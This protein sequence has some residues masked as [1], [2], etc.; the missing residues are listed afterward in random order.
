M[1]DVS[2]R[3]GSDQPK[4][5]LEAIYREGAR[6]CL[7]P[8]T[9]LSI[10]TISLRQAAPLGFLSSATIVFI[11]GAHLNRAN[12]A[13]TGS[14]WLSAIGFFFVDGRGQYEQVSA[15]PS[16]VSRDGARGSLSF[17][18]L[19]FGIRWLW[20]LLKEKG[21]RGRGRNCHQLTS[22]ELC[23][24]VSHHSSWFWAS[25]PRCPVA[26]HYE[27]A[28]QYT[29]QGTL[30]K[31]HCRCHS[32]FVARSRSVLPVPASKKSNSAL[33]GATFSN[34]ATSYFIVI[35]IMATVGL[36]SI[37]ASTHDVIGHPFRYA[38]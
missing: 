21:G 24:S 23:T 34:G 17:E 22:E 35:L 28:A 5:P 4:L 37:I 27:D 3:I 13:A 7:F 14:F 19:M 36:L 38:R 30:A 18:I 8:I 6:K 26:F 12:V 10:L 16:F 1:L 20:L 15:P 33:H 31:C 2:F 9:T 25:P 32:P 29:V 11:A